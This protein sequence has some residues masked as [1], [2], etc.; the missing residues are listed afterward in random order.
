MEIRAATYP[1]HGDRREAVPPRFRAVAVE[2]KLVQAFYEPMA[3]AVARLRR[4]A[5]RVETDPARFRSL[6]GRPESDPARCRP[7]AIVL[8][9]I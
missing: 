3:I 6:G 7:V 9:P 8:K 4:V 5:N 1:S 2:L